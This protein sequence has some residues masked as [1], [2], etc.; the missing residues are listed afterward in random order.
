M[1]I[2]DETLFIAEEP[3]DSGELRFRYSRKLSSDG[4][5]W[6]RDGLFQEF[7]RN[8]TPA[9][10]GVY[11]DDLEEGL[12][13]EYYESGQ[14]SSEGQYKRGKEE[15]LWKFWNEQGEREED[16]KFRDGQEIS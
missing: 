7:H 1:S 12:W 3:Y 13:R 5:R 8:G 2:R 11:R 10:E 4:K 16:I 15:G 6:I 9:A 14:I